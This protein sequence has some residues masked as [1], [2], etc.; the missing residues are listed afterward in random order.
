ML[1]DLITSAWEQTFRLMSGS[2]VSMWRT[3]RAGLTA[4]MRS[5]ELMSNAYARLWGALPAEVV[6]DDSRFS[7]QT[8]REN[9]AFDMVRQVYLI[10][11]QWMTDVAEG[12]EGLNPDLGQ[13]AVFWTKQLADALSPTNFAV[14]NPA[15]L[16]ETIRTGGANLM[17]GLQNLLDDLQEGRIRMV[18]PDAFQVGRDLAVTPGKV[19]YRNGLIE[20]IQYSPTTNQVRAAPVLAIPP[21]INKYYVMDMRPE[22][23]MFRHLVDSGLT[24]FTISWKNPD[25]NMR[26]MTWDDYMDLGP[27]DAMRVIRA[28]TGADRVNL[29]GYCLGGLMLQTTL[30]YLAAVGDETV[31]TATFFATHQDFTD[32]GDIAVFMSQAEAWFLDWLMTLSGGYLDGRNMAATFNML[33]ANDLV[34]HYVINNYLMGE[35]PPAFDLLYWNSDST[36]APHKVHM[37]LVREFFLENRLKEPNGLHLKGVGIDVG[38]IRTPTY[39]VAAQA[40]HIVPW[41]GAFQICHLMGG[42]VRFVL[43]ESGHIAGIINPPA[44]GKRGYWIDES[45]TTDADEWF[46]RATHHRGSWWVDWLPWLEARSGALIPPPPTGNDEFPPLQDAPGRYVLE[47]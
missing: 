32:V 46:A 11:A 8:W 47:R 3:Q 24:V 40:D 30:A 5:L 31:N 28:I 39:A 6:S 4:A 9:L 21:W 42:P 10:T 15:V 38:R 26:E 14:T 16:Q 13:R 44:S 20:L 22:N 35:R 1:T 25:G 37:F 34:W 29:I 18:A 27:L 17:R 33:R 43:A 41:R 19:V 36:R 23:S 7:H 2:A 12:L 45:N